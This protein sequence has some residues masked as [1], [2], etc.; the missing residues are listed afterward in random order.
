MRNLHLFLSSIEHETRLFKEARATLDL[1]IFDDVRVLGLQ[2]F[3]RPDD[4]IHESGLR[5]RRLRTAS[6]RQVSSHRT[7][8]RIRRV[9]NAGLSLVQYAAA[10]I[11]EA[12]RGKPSHITCHNPILLPIAFLAARTCGA[13]VVYAPHELEAERTGLQGLYRKCS[14]AAERH[15]APLCASVV[16]VCKPIADWYRDRYG[17]K[18]V[19]VVRAIPEGRAVA[20]RDM[21]A[22]EQIRSAH[23]VPEHALLFIYQGLLE[24]ARGIDSL[25]DAFLGLDEPYHLMF[26]GYGS[27]EHAI[28]E[29]MLKSPRIH[30]QPAVPVDEIVRYSAAADVGIF[31]L[32]N[33]VSRSYAL[34]L[35]NK[36]FEYL[37]AGLPVVVSDNLELLSALV[38]EHRLGWVVSPLNLAA[39]VR[40]CTP[41]AIGGFISDVDRFAAENSWQNEKQVFRAIYK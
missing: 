24:S 37:C 16:V 10:S 17:L 34:C 15:F 26:M 13:K 9:V 40:S 31:V 7:G 14:A 19:H 27:S 3:G 22:R 39:V 21:T 25:I 6:S 33:P 30:F 23:G 35:P 32:A 41:E 36:F 38:A 8:S 2:A 29:A 5:I 4:E 18:V 20:A 12:W 1:G 28:R 11:Q